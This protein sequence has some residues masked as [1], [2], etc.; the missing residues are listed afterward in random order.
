MSIESGML[1]KVVTD[2]TDNTDNTKGTN[3]GHRVRVTDGDYSLRLLGARSGALIY[4]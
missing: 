3:R 4:I 1:R 2:N